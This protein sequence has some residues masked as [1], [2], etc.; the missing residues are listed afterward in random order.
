M[1][2]VREKR[3]GVVCHSAGLT[4]GGVAYRGEPLTGSE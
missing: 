3:Y 4:A 2:I 1:R